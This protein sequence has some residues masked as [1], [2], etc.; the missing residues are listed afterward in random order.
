M[1]TGPEIIKRRNLGQ[2][3]I[4][5]FDEKSVGPNSYDVRIGDTIATVTPNANRDELHVNTSLPSTVCTLYP[6]EEGF[7][8]LL[9]GR[10]YLA[11]TVETIGSELYVPVLHGRS[12]T[13]RHGLAVHITAGFCDL[14]FRGQIVLELVNFTGY[15]M[16]V[17]P[18]VRIAQVSFHPVT[19]DIK[20]YN[21]TYQNQQ[22]IVRAKALT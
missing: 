10:A 18:G 3:T 5:P 13:A 17:R 22:G 9:P 6:N 21:S 7:L 15:P 12:S 4:E 14:G 11:H 8:V 2:I 1:L 19:G 16:L 20:L